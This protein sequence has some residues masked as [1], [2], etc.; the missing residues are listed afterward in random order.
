MKPNQLE[1]PPLPRIFNPIGKGTDGGCDEYEQ[2]TKGN[3]RI[4]ITFTHCP[5]LPSSFFIIFVGTLTR[6]CA[7]QIG[8][9]KFVFL[10]F[11]NKTPDFVKMIYICIAER[12]QVGKNVLL[13]QLLR[14]KVIQRSDR[15]EIV[16]ICQLIGRPLVRIGR[17]RG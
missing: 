13:F 17:Q 3:A 10:V 12:T 4:L 6:H 14:E 7:T 11:F 8:L 16:V 2:K 5:P 1:Y 9:S 15:I